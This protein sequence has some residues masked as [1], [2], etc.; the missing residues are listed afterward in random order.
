MRSF[1]PDQNRTLDSLVNAAI[2]V[3]SA[4]TWGMISLLVV[5]F[6]WGLIVIVGTMLSWAR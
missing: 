4:L 6:I 3:V 5:A 2:W 1:L